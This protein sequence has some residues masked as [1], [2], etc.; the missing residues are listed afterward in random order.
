MHETF[1]PVLS[2]RGL[3]KRFGTQIAV[4]DLSLEVRHGDIYGLLG[5]NGAGKTTTMRLALGLIRADAGEVRVFGAADP[6]G[7]LRSMARVGAMVEGPAFYGHLSGS[8]NLRLLG[9]LSGPLTR[10]RVDEILELVGLADA[11]KKK[12]RNYSLGMKQRLGI[13]L[14]LVSRPELVILDEPTNGLDPNG[15][16]EMRRLIRRLNR[17]EGTTFI[18]SSHLLFEIEQ[19]CNRVAIL[20]RG[21]LVAEQSLDELMKAE[22]DRYLLAASPEEDARRLVAEHAELLETDDD[23]IAFRCPREGLPALHRALAEASVTVY[24][25]EERRRSLE[26]IFLAS[27]SEGPG[28]LT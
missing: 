19:V 20:E 11:A 25:L 13:G 17:E 26:E 28:A 9:S 21:R 8:E 27:S 15:I 1:D 22:A 2:T 5:L 18:I 10:A 3:T 14:A 7:R 24:T 4:D 16:L 23:Q 12:A 6:R